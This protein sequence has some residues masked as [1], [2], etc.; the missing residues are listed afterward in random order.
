V[1]APLLM[2]GACNPELNERTHDFYQTPRCA[3]ESLL[4]VEGF[5]GPIWESACGAGAI[6]SVLEEYGHTVY[7]TDLIDRGFGIGGVDF[8]KEEYARA[9][10]IVTNPPF[11]RSLEFVRHARRLATGKTAI[12]CRTL[13]LESTARYNG[14]FKADPP[15]RVWQ[16]SKRLPMMHREGWTGI[17]STP[18]IAYMWFVWDRDNAGQTVL[19]WLP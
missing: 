9:T 16:F 10:N 8:L 13:W 2:L 14:L 12:L 1:N 19:G 4:S 5:D 17:K 15:A 18:A 3:V 7:S 11:N 6:S